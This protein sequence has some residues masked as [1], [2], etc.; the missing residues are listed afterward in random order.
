MLSVSPLA[1]AS[2]D[3]LY[4]SNL[5]M[6]HGPGRVQRAIL[7]LIDADPD[8]AWLTTEV[9]RHVYAIDI[10]EK[11]HRVAVSRAQR[12][13]IF[14]TPGWTATRGRKGEYILYN[15]HNPGS[16]LRAWWKWKFAYMSF[17][18]FR[19]LDFAKRVAAD[20]MFRHADKNMFADFDLDRSMNEAAEDLRLAE[21]AK[22]PHRVEILQRR[23]SKLNE[24]RRRSSIRYVLV[25]ELRAREEP[26]DPIQSERARKSFKW[27]LL[28]EVYG[29]K[30]AAER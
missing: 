7:D 14:P 27:K 15:E 30:D 29:A 12:G 8:G 19:K 18:E 17:D 9:C 16:V 22:D 6:S 23:L 24:A 25:E 28:E 11:R 26:G 5:S 1:A 10:V 2:L 20:V 4:P 3:S 21:K 13:T